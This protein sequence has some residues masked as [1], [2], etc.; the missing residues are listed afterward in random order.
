[1]LGGPAFVYVRNAAAELVKIDR[2]DVR[3]VLRRHPPAVIAESAAGVYNSLA[4]AIVAS[5]APAG[6]AAH[7]IS[8]DKAYRIGQYSVGALGN[9]LQGWVVEA[10]EGGLGRR[11]RIV[12]LLHASMG[13]VGLAAFGVLGPLLTDLLFGPDVAI[14][15]TTAF[16]FGVA[17]LG[18][19]LGTAFGRIGLITIGARKAFMTCVLAASVTG[20]VALLI[21]GALWG[22]EGA[23]WALGMTELLSA[24]AQ[25]TLLAVL[26]R[27]RIAM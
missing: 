1:M 17:I 27:K 24:L 14:G 4:V 7:Y 22:A 9:A 5:I 23:A 25:G 12:I 3:A 20:A 26:W 6:E 21:G 11:L 15:E 13:M 19:A 2:D 10:R 16:G 8:G 18:I